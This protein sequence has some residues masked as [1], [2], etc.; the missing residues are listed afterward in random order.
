MT[1]LIIKKKKN[2]LPCDETA[3]ERAKS[4]LFATI[5]TGRV[6]IKSKSCN[7]IKICSIRVYDALSTTE[8]TNTNASAFS[9]SSYKINEHKNEKEKDKIL[10]NHGNVTFNL[11]YF[12]AFL[13]NEKF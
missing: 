4:I 12:A 10:I 6:R 11:N 5:I 8:Y 1:H 13:S 3:L 9:N 2:L 7:V